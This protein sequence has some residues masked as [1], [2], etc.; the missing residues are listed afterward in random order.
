MDKI[1]SLHQSK[2]NIQECPYKLMGKEMWRNVEVLESVGWTG[3][4]AARR[5]EWNRGKGMMI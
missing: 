3:T 1:L 5:V 2:L 4:L